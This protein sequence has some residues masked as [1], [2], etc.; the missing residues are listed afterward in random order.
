[1]DAKK[2]L[3][4][5]NLFRTLKAVAYL[6]GYPLF[7]LLLLQ[8][9]YAMGLGTKGLATEILV[10][11][12]AVVTAI[13]ILVTI[14]TRSYSARA[15][16]VIIVTVILL[17][18]FSVV[19]DMRAESKLTAAAESYTRDYYRLEKEDKVNLTVKNDEIYAEVTY[20]NG[21]KETYLTPIKSY[22]E[23]L[24]EFKPW[25]GGYGFSKERG[26]L[27]GGLISTYN[28]NGSGGGNKNTDGS[29]GGAA[30]SIN[31][32]DPEYWFGEKGGVYNPNGLYAD[33]YIFGVEQTIQ[34]LLT[35]YRTQD[36]YKEQGLDADEALAAA[37]A[38]VEASPEWIEYKSSAEYQEAYGTDGYAYNYMFTEERLNDFLMSLGSGLSEVS[39]VKTLLS[40]GILPITA[41]QLAGLDLQGAAD[42]VDGLG[43]D[44]TT[45]AS[46]MGVVV[47]EG[48]PTKDIL[49]K[50]VQKFYYYQVPTILPSMYFIKDETLRTYA[51]AKYYAEI[52]GAN[53]ACVLYTEDQ[54]NG[55]IGCITMSDSGA[56]ASAAYSA[57]ELCAIRAYN[58]YTGNFFPMLLFRR[59]AMF[60]AGFTALAYLLSY[61]FAYKQ[62][63][64]R[65]IIQ[66]GIYHD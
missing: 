41:E 65:L 42:L 33:S 43:L 18:G 27:Q 50:L 11:S 55:H 32:N 15:V 7:F 56:P 17:L 28:I 45:I 51:Y 14:I 12:W 36:D 24:S 59:Y 22:N 26:G 58:S 6:L 31:G 30:P 25:S 23:H 48:T 21:E 63:L 47:P 35:I 44:L 60:F 10:V 40:L 29:K 16:S 57:E 38:E 54:E 49:V 66:D 53:N 2:A 13:Q 61:F 5:H 64:Y 39:L 19:F 1:M 20:S 4:R 46:G 52:H 34:I 8:S 3:R 37:Y 62:S 9:A